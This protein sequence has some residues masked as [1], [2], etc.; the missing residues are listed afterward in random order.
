M[1]G[2]GVHPLGKAWCARQRRSSRPNQ[3]AQE[4]GCD[5]V[6][7]TASGEAVQDTRGKGE[8]KMSRVA[9]VAVGALLAVLADSSWASSHGRMKQAS[10]NYNPAINPQ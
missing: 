10:N 3:R 9:Y 8:M 5:A 1:G 2:D 7:A 6:F 4:G